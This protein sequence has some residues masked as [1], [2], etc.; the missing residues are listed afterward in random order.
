M[1]ACDQCGSWFH[2]SCVGINEEMAEDMEKENLPF[3][4][5]ECK[6]LGILNKNR[7]IQQNGFLADPLSRCFPTLSPMKQERDLVAKTVETSVLD[8][9]LQI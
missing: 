4:C 2:G 6:K 9:T 3:V 7:F 5:P 1:I 8:I